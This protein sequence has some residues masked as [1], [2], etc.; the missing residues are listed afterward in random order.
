MGFSRQ[1]YWVGCHFLLQGILCTCLLQVSW[2]AG[3]FFTTKPRKPCNNCEVKVAQLCPTL[4]DPHGQSMEFSSSILQG[5]L[6]TQV[7]HIEGRFFTSWATREAKNTGVGS[8]SLLQQIFLTQEL[9]WGLL[10]CRRIL[11]QLSYMYECAQ[12]DLHGQLR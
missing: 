8:L 7:S 11:Y 10:Y 6:P 4:C 3:G 9:N 1:E 12:K 5:V 2:I